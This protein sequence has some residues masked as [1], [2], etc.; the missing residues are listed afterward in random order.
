MTRLKA[1]KAVCSSI[2]VLMLASAAGA[3]TTSATTGAMNGTVTDNTTAVLP[4]VTVTISSPAMMGTRTD[5]TNAQGQYRFAAVA[6]GE[7][8]ITFEL[9]GFANVVR[10]GVRVTLGFTATINAE[11]E[12]ATQRETITVVGSSPV[13]DTQATKVTTNYDAQQMA[14]L[15][16][17]R[18]YAGLMSTTPAVKVNRIDVGGSTSL[19]EQNYRVYGI[20][21]Q[22]DRPLVEGMLASEGTSLLYYTDYGS[23][24]EVSVGAAGNSA[25]MPGSGVFSQFIAKS[26][27]NTYHGTF[28][29]DYYGKNWSTRNIDDEQIALG[30]TGGPSLDAKDTNR[31]TSYHDTNGDLG[32]YLLKDKLWWYG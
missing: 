4:G 16:N 10:D 18:D 32:G 23:F 8:R 11:L 2:F 20:P 24:A 3:Q 13:V 28:Y 25:E 1:P 21:N 30:V 14:N 29:Q 17:A 22:Q 9:P 12:L 31:T 27:G 6:P 7:Y 19:S 15:P 26:G 5:V